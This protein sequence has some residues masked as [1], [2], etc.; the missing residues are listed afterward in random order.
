VSYRTEGWLEKNRD[1]I[2]LTVASLF[3]NNKGN[4]VLATVFGDIGEDGKEK[5][6]KRGT[7]RIRNSFLSTCHRVIQSLVLFGIILNRCINK[8]YAAFV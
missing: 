7:A 1:H 5:N 6:N 2:N 3:K 4:K 8:L